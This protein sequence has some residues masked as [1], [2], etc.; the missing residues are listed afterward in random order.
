M[1][2]VL[3]AP[4]EDNSGAMALVKEQSA[5]PELPLLRA[6]DSSTTNRAPTATK[7]LCGYAAEEKEV[8]DLRKVDARLGKALVVREPRRPKG[9]RE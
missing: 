7:K 3:F 2:L 9:R 1:F 4:A 8:L 6:S 5:V